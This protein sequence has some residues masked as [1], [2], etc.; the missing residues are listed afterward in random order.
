MLGSPGGWLFT[1]LHNLSTRMSIFETGNFSCSAK[2]G[3]SHNRLNHPG[4]RVE[5]DVSA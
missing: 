4:K 2:I 5:V 3:S 1:F